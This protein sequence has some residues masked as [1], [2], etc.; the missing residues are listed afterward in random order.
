MYQASDSVNVSQNV[1][2]QNNG[3]GL[4]IYSGG[5]PV[6]VVQNLITGNQGTGLSWVLPPITAISN[7]IANNTPGGCCGIVGSEIYAPDADN[8]VILENNLVVATGSDPAFYCGYAGSAPT[9]KN[10]DIFSA[11][12]AAYGGT[13]QDATGTNGNISADPLCRSAR[14]QLPHSIGVTRSKGGDDFSS[15]RTKGRY[16]WRPARHRRNY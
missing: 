7:T 9:L 8:T 13:C 3:N 11:N 1:I 14:R 10:N 16:G 2:T 15:T 4:F 12:S 6:T 5:G